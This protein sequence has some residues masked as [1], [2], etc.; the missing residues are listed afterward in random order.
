MRTKTCPISSRYKTWLAVCGCVLLVF[1]F[2]LAMIPT[3]VA[4]A[5][6]GGWPTATPTITP[7]P[8]TLT[9]PPP[10]PMFLPTLE[11][12]FPLTFQPTPTFTPAA[13]GASSDFAAPEIATTIGPNDPAS[14]TSP[15]WTCLPLGAIALLLALGFLYLR[16]PKGV[17]R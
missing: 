9:L 12:T 15:L 8:P 17:T 6:A 5:D 2:G 11:P 3:M 4:S 16:R 10:T 13:F 1:L 7:V 14:G